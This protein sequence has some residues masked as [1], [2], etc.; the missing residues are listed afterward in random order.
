M[1]E[2]KI[3]ENGISSVEKEL[4]DQGYQQIVRVGPEKNVLEAI[5]K[6]CRAK[7]VI[8]DV[9]E[10]PTPHSC[11]DDLTLRVW[12][13]RAKRLNGEFLVAQ[14]TVRPKLKYPCYV[15]FLTQSQ[16]DKFLKESRIP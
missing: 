12:Q 7:V 16:Y 9:V 1:L 6:N 8:V 11:L 10:H 14:V 13:S 15:E 5:G 3:K 2:P 4:E